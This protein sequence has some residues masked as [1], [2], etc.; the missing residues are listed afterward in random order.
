MKKILAIIL[1][2]GLVSAL[3]VGGVA[4]AGENSASKATAAVADI[5][6]LDAPT[7]PTDTGWD[8]VLV[9]DIKTANQKDLFVDVSL[10]CELYTDTEVT[11]KSK[12]PKTTGNA[13]GEI[14]VRVGATDPGNPAADGD[15]IVWAQPTGD[16]SGI[17]FAKR[18]QELWAQ[19]ST[20]NETDW[21]TIGLFLDTAAAHSFNF[22][23][24]DLQ[25]GMHSV[26][27]EA[28]LVTTSTT[29]DPLVVANAKAGL[30]YGSVTIEEVRMVKGE[31]VLI[32][33]D[34]DP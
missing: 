19:L 17:V 15:G 1:S 6:W 33:S 24:E 22:I 11:A 28:K 8:V 21:V 26:M 27:V 3:V 4:L 30:G 13:M 29:G 9:Q 23:I 14:M 18:E 16:D 12:G 7:S 25:S 2:L 32:G 34:P 20:D 31:S 10:L 5:T